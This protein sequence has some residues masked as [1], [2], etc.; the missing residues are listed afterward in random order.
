M[1][2]KVSIPVE[3]V[4]APD[5]WYK[6]TGITFDRDFFFHPKRRVEDEQKMEKELYARWGRHG[7]G[8]HHDQPRPEIGAVHLACGYILADMMGCEVLYREA[9]SPVVVCAHFDD[10]GQDFYEK[11]FRSKTYADFVSMVER[12][13]QQFG[14]VTGN[15]NFAGILNIAIDLVGQDIFLE[16]YDN[17]EACKA[18]FDNIYRAINRFTGYIESKTGTTSTSVNRS[19]RHQKDPIFLHSLCPLTMLSE[20]LYEEFLFPFDK[21]FSEEKKAYGIHYCGVDPHRFAPIFSTLPNLAFLDV[22]WGGDIPLIRKH[23]PNTFL[24]LRLS[25]AEIVGQTP[26]EITDTVHRLVKESANPELTG[27]CCINIDSTVKEEQ[28][29]AIFDAVNSLDSF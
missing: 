18:L 13:E 11:A 6:H 28:I 23:L 2:Q 10:M 29:D 14:Y 21:K 15:V 20:D 4:F 8:A 17:P 25:P 26:G 3:V 7:L 24:N 27:V 19:V 12:L 16:M 1:A 9:D 5:W 22:G